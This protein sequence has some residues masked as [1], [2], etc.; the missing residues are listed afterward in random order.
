[1]SAEEKCIDTFQPVTIAYKRFKRKH[2][3]ENIR[4]VYEETIAC[5][6]IAEKIESDNALNTGKVF[7]F[8]LL[9][10]QRK[11]ALTVKMMTNQVCQC[12]FAHSLQRGRSAFQI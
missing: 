7:D 12:I 8:S 11:N 10:L 4:Q 6:D 3:P 5:F 2:F 1:M 9:C